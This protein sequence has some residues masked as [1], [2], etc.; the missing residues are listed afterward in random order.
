M[1][2]REFITLLG[3]AA[4]WPI[5]APAQ[6]RQRT[7]IGWLGGS[8]RQI[9]TRNLNAF[10]QGLR[11]YGHEDGKDIDIVYRW[12][13]GDQSRQPALA[14]ELV[15]LSPA[16]IVAAVTPAIVALRQFTTTI[17][18][19][20]ALLAEP[21]SLGL[22]ES[23]NRP[24]LNV[25]GILETLDTLPAKQIELLIQVS[26]SAKAVG[27]LI[28]PASPTHPIMLRGVEAA[29]RGTS[30]TLVP[31]EARTPVD[32]D[33]AFEAMK[34]NRVDSLIVFQD[35]MFF[36][37]EARIVALAEAMRLPTIYGFRQHVERGGLMS[38]G[39]VIPQNFRR[40]AYFVDRILKG[41][42]AGDLPLE[43][44]AKLE[45]VINLKTA[46]TL[47]LEVPSKLLFTADEVIE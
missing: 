4:A 28:N 11:E 13:E 23:Y 17:P 37:E 33:G 6:P 41:A 31:T 35:A 46:K 1:R 8:S 38:Y 42:R 20:G 18:I 10:L 7:V 2:R 15:A 24:G 34:R 5:A 36:T 26:P 19:V 45:L 32:L 12:A 16:V 25:T 47:G 30:V 21:L 27:V 40:A 44:P 22:A 3:G 14:K 9:A 39:V 29:V 43:L